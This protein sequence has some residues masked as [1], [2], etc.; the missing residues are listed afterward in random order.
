MGSLNELFLN[1]CNIESLPDGIF[2]RLRNLRKLDLS[3]NQINKVERSLFARLSVLEELNLSFNK[4][5]KI[6]DYC[7]AG[8][9]SSLHVHLECNEPG[10]K[11]SFTCMTFGESSLFFKYS[12]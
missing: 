6:P 1:Y 12:I 10:L 5:K 3:Q 2:Q 9:G 7:F 8:V 4:L 11:E